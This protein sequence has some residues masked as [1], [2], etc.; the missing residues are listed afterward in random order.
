V[1]TAAALYYRLPRT[2]Q[3]FYRFYSCCFQDSEAYKLA[4]KLYAGRYEMIAAR[5]AAD[6]LC[7]LIAAYRPEEDKQMPSKSN[8]NRSYA[9]EPKINNLGK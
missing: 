4:L 8:K 9:V 3:R 5:D 7:Q 6:I 1:Y 2:M